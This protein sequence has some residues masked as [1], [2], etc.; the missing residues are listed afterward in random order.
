MRAYSGQIWSRFTDGTHRWKTFLL[1][2]FV[3]KSD[4][5]HGFKASFRLFAPK[6]SRQDTC[7]TFPRR[8][9]LSVSPNA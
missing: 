5:A 2:C 8:S 4:N 6:L 7:H 3:G 1:V 9:S